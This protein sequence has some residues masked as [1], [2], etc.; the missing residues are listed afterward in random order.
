MKV[1]VKFLAI[2]MLAGVQVMAAAAPDQATRDRAF[3]FVVKERNKA[4]DW[5]ADAKTLNALLDEDQKALA[6]YR[7]E[8]I[9][10]G[11][12][13]DPRILVII[14]AM[15][16]GQRAR[17]Q[18]LMGIVDKCGWPTISE[19]GKTASFSAYMLLQHSEPED[20]LPLLETLRAL[21]AAGEVDKANYAYLTDRTLLAQKKPQRYGTQV[22]Q[23][24][25][26]S[27]TVAG[28]I[29]D[30]ER[31]DERRRDMNIIPGELCVYLSMMETGP[32][33]V[34]YPRCKQ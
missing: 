5:L 21:S 28:E 2:A 34:S 23:L 1:A 13:E 6:G 20:Q 14:K 18:K 29:E 22:E 9:P 19:F 3:A 15:I 24:D 32:T 16:A 4:C 26:G 7:A 30:P 11:E 10:N 27:W 31:V 17:T 12:H 33:K 8:K 25:D